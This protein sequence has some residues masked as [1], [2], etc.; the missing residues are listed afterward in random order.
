MFFSL[1][2]SVFEGVSTLPPFH[3]LRW[4]FYQKP[5][6]GVSLVRLSM[7]VVD[8]VKVTKVEQKSNGE[9]LLALLY[10]FSF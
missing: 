7:A 4:D 8:L 1:L 6:S 10:S 5:F 9:C 3:L 2:E